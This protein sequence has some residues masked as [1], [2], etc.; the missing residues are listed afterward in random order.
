MPMLWALQCHPAL[1]WRDNMTKTQITKAFAALQAI[2]APVFNKPDWF[3]I[4][5]EDNYDKDTKEFK[6]WASADHDFMHPEIVTILKRNGLNYEWY[7]SGTAKI[8]AA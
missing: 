8:F 5:A 6:L 4:S 1:N 3:V 7:D 2:G